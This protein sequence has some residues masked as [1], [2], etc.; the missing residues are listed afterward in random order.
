MVV[1]PEMDSC[2]GAQAKPKQLEVAKN[3]KVENLVLFEQSP[4]STFMDLQRRLD[5]IRSPSDSKVS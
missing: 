4:S 1:L 2:E 3:D 5:Q